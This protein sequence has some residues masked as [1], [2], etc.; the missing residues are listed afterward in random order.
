MQRRIVSR[1]RAQH[2][3]PIACMLLTALIGIAAPGC[4]AEPSEP[5]EPIVFPESKRLQIHEDDLT[6]HR[7]IPFR[8][9]L[10]ADALGTGSR[11]VR[12]SSDDGRHLEFDGEV[13]PDPAAAGVQDESSA[14]GYVQFDLERD[15]L[16][17]GVYVIQVRT[18]EVSAVPLR[19]YVL[20]IVD[21]P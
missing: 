5:A 6:R 11:P 13:I 3:V 7:Q 19:R 2:R 12:A 15:W 9:A 10:A 4:E 20:Q 8:V 21:E 17:P 14:A 16:E 18:A 1:R